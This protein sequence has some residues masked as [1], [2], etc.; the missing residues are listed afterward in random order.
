MLPAQTLL[1]GNINMVLKTYGKIT[2]DIFNK[3]TEK[4]RKTSGKKSPSKCYHNLLLNKTTLI[5]V[6]SL[7]IL[8]VQ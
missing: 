2:K 4:G 3:L 7:L 1:C 5:K 6:V 8:Y